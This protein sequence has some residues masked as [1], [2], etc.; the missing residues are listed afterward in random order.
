MTCYRYGCINDSVD[1]C[2]GAVSDAMRHWWVIVGICHVAAGTLL[3]LGALGAHV[4]VHD[5]LLSPVL[6]ALTERHCKEVKIRH[7][8]RKECVHLRLNPP[9]HSIDIQLTATSIKR[10]PS[11]LSLSAIA[12][13]HT[14]VAIGAPLS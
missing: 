9:S 7:T 8:E 13:H 10:S 4:I 1:G 12:H 5:I 11:L 2:C 14:C 6:K 3:L